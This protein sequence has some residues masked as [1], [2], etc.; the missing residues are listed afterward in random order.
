[1]RKLSHSACTFDISSSRADAQR[2]QSTLD[3]L[4]MTSMKSALDEDMVA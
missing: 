1:L 3:G 2:A 4:Q